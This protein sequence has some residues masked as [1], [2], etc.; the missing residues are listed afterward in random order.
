[1]GT[2]RMLWQILDKLRFSGNLYGVDVSS[3]MCEFV[4]KNIKRERKYTQNIKIIQCSIKEAPKKIRAKSSF[5]I[6]SF[7]FP[8]KI[9][10]RALCLDELRAVYEVLADGGDFF[11][12]GWDESFNDELNV[13]WFKYIP[14]NIQA[15]D[16]EEWRRKRSDFITTPRNCQ[17]SWFK[18]GI[19]A[20]L[21]FSS[22]KE[23]SYV[24]GN[25]FGRDAAQYIIQNNKMEW[26]MSLGITHNTKEELAAIIRN[27][28][29]G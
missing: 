13:L 3:N 21:Q 29:R 22:L 23:A 18:K 10:N 7:G 24:M 6:S 17:L 8:S 4:K 14:D 1:M 28:E 2:G 12:I 25:L 5:V 27:Y 20:P 11:T 26:T 15:N 9:T 19:Q 16:F